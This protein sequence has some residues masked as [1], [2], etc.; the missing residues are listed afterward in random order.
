MIKLAWAGTQDYAVPADQIT[1]VDANT[2]LLRI[3]TGEN[4]DTWQVTVTNPGAVPSS[5][6]FSVL[7]PRQVTLDLQLPVEGA[8]RVTDE[9]N[10][11]CNNATGLWTACQHKTGFHRASGGISGSEE[12]YAWDLNL[13]GDLDASKPV[14]AVAPGRIVKYAGQVAPGAVS[15]AL[16]IEH[17]TNGLTWWS[18]YLHMSDISL[19]EGS[20]V[21]TST[22]LGR[23]SNLCDCGS[24]PNHLHVV[25]YYGSNTPG[26]LKSRDAI[27]RERPNVTQS[28]IL[29]V[30]DSRGLLWSVNPVTLTAT[31]IGQMSTVMND[32]AMSPAGELFG[33][34]SGR[35]YRVNPTTAVIERIGGSYSSMNALG[36]RSDGTLFGASG[37][38]IY[39][40]NTS[41]WQQSFVTQISGNSDGDLDFSDLGFLYI[42]TV[43]FLGELTRV[44]LTTGL[45]T[46]LGRVGFPSLFGLA[47]APAGTFYAFSGSRM[48]RIDSVT[49]Q[50]E[51]MH[52]FAAAGLRDIYGATTVP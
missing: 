35:L 26:G 36:F 48:I 30:S 37:N 8:F 19:A 39:T 29:Y 24:V 10:S 44:D 25:I 6:V 1:I 9:S 5:K 40:I 14:F 43:S 15:G 4:A 34:T 45:S 38:R 32:I 23:I 49:G 33:T 27:F 47:R 50:G 17:E 3:T 41:D 12:T 52:D 20:D 16:L 46:K 28:G 51:L 31:E 18:G 13:P 22:Q 7:D 21:T 11:D 42:T 2:I